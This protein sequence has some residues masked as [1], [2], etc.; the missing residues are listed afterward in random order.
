MISGKNEHTSMP[1]SSMPWFKRAC[2]GPCYRPPSMYMYRKPL[3]VKAMQ[4]TKIGLQAH[5]DEWAKIGCSVMTD[6]C[7]IGR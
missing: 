1:F 3:L 6:A 5:L 7:L 2:Y 4:W